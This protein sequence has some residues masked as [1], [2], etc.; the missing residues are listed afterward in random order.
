MRSKKPT[1]F[2]SFEDYV[3]LKFY[4]VGAVLF[5][6]LASGVV[7]L[8]FSSIL[9]ARSV[10]QAY[11]VPTNN[12]HY[13]LGSYPTEISYLPFDTIIPMNFPV[14][15]KNNTNFNGTV[16]SITTDGTYNFYYLVTVYI[17]GLAAGRFNLTLAAF[18]Q[19]NIRLA[20]SS[21]AL[22]VVMNGTYTI[23]VSLFLTKTYT[24]SDT[25]YSTL[26]YDSVP[27]TTQANFLYSNTAYFI[28][29]QLY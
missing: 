2:K 23:P 10:P 6:A 13:I 5:L 11:Q 22:P 8:V 7:G 19:N 16:F 14:G 26:Y 25:I 1:P 24:T 3:E 9:L 15:I 29:T 18:N 27:G 28:A 21:F 12:A 4:I 17:T 20:A